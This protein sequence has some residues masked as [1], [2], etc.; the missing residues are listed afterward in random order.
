MKEDD[1]V[2]IYRE[3][4]ALALQKGIEE[5][6]DWEDF[7]EELHDFVD[8]YEPTWIERRGHRPPRFPPALWN[9]HDSIMN[10]VVNNQSI[11]W[12]LITGHGIA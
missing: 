2:E 6:E 3:H 9:H 11:T 12:N 10:D 8:Y 5:N 4:I 7:A 1:V